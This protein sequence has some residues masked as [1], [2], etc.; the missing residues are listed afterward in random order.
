MAH[1]ILTEADSSTLWK[2]VMDT[3]Q[4]NQKE[5]GSIIHNGLLSI[6]IIG[7]FTVEDKQLTIDNVN[8]LGLRT[9]LCEV[10]H[11]PCVEKENRM[12]LQIVHK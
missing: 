4:F 6:R 8:K 2:V 5:L 9:Q 1:L 11:S 7:K 10:Y 3:M 12:E